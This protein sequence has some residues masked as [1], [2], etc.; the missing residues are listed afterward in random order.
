MKKSLK[1]AAALALAA[2]MAAGVL[3]SCGEKNTETKTDDTA[4]S[5]GKIVMGTNAE[6]PPFEFVADEGQGLVDKFDG[7]DIA[8]AKKI[9]DKLGKELVIEDMQF[10]GLVASAQ[11]GKVDFVAAGMTASDERR[12]SVDFSDT[13]YVAKQVM[14]VA[15]D[16]DTIKSAEDLKNASKVGVV[17]GYTGDSVVTDDLQLDDSK[18]LR[19]SR[20][21]DGVQEVKNGKLDAMVI[22]SATGIALAEKNGLKVV[23]D[24]DVFA[25]EEYAIAVKK[26]NTELLNTINET[27]KEMK[28]AGEI[29]ELAI[30]YNG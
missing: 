2:I 29:D 22:D 1:K 20:G 13:Y 10:E 30:K 15:A 5:S 11:S 18:I 7:I 25:A 9:A 12:Q 8:I 3:S 19:V 17:L 26:G 4:K 24:D 27:L 14:V 6:F 23:E 21:I 16:N 28:A